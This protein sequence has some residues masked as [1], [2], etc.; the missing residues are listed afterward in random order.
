MGAL[1]PACGEYATPLVAPATQPTPA[2]ASGA[3][4]LLAFAPRCFAIPTHT[5]AE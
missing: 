4:L 3:G 5:P 2:M 1:E